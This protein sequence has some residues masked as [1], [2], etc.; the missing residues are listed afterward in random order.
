V[1]A[2][3]TKVRWKYCSS[4]QR[5]IFPLDKKGDEMM[6]KSTA[7]V[8]EKTGPTKLHESSIELEKNLETWIEKDPSLVQ[9]GLIILHRQLVLDGGRLDLLAL[10]PQGRMVVIEIKT[11]FLDNNVITQAFYYVAQIAKMP[12]YN[13][14]AKV[15]SYLEAQNIQLVQLLEERGVDIVSQQDE[16]E[17]LAIVVGTGRKRGFAQMLDY[18][19]IK[20]E[21]PITSVIFDVFEVPDGKRVLVRERTDADFVK[22]TSTDKSKQW[23]VE[24]VLESSRKS[25][26]YDEFQIFLDAAKKHNL[27]PRPYASSIMFTSPQNKSRMLFTVW[28]QLNKDGKLKA[29]VGAEGF[30]EFYPIAEDEVRNF[31]GDDGWRFM[32]KQDVVVFVSELDNMFKEIAS[33]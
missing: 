8:I 10:D 28:A 2:Q 18:Y 3:Q 27:H 23:S 13:L 31:L 14:S 7:W 4:K 5:I 17:A 19:A 9:N 12:F 22:A 30:A 29:Y 11:G 20:Y 33:R 32:S 24:N 16:R 26:I 15:D 1:V 21:V 25:A 6:S